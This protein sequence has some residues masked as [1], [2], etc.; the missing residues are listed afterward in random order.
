MSSPV[1][2]RVVVVDGMLGK[3]ARWLRMLGVPALYR[4]SW[5]DEELLAAL[6]EPGSLLLTR[7]KGLAR[8]AA[9]AGLSVLLLPQARVEDLL[10]IVLPVLGVEARFDQGRALCP[11]CG[12]PLRRAGPGEVAGRVPERVAG[13]YSEFYVCTGCGQVY[14]MGSHMRQIESTLE[15]VRRI[16]HG[17][18]VC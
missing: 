5:S 7:D 6:G 17:K 15:R 12:S 13:A 16:V 18:V 11:L 8:R 1:R 9:R 10:A 4:S 14:W 3:L 2:Y